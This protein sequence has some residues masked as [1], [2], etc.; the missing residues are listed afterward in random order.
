MFY[1]KFGFKVSFGIL[2]RVI[3]GAEKSA[4]QLIVTESV[5]IIIF[6]LKLV[7]Q[8]IESEQN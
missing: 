6:C 1:R 4:Y 2:E 3:Y 8:P 5:F 7:V